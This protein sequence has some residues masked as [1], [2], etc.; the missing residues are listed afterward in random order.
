MYHRAITSVKTSEGIGGEFPITIG[1]HQGSELSPQFFALVMDEITN[2][3]QEEIPY[4]ILFVY[5]IIFV[6]ET[7]YEVNAKFKI[8]RNAL[9]FKG[10]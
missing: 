8:W 3:I 4:Y 1:V 6:D 2:S 5:D 10:F 9:E 7:R